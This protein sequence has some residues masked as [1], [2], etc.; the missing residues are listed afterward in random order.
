M[1]ASISVQMPPEMGQ[2]S[3]VALF[4]RPFMVRLGN[5]VVAL[6]RLRTGRGMGADGQPFKGYSTTPIYIVK[7]GPTGQRLSPKGGRLSR[8][9][10]SVYYEGGYR[11]FKEQSRRGVG[12]A[13]VDLTLS[14]E[15]L[16]SVAVRSASDTSVTVGT[17]DRVLHAAKVDAA[18]PFVGIA[19]DEVSVLEGIVGEQVE[20]RLRALFGG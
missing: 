19:P 20:S 7:N 1:R 5:D 16:R 15:M 9:G 4:G 13:E 11:Q 8:T 2:P 12:G 6:I 3:A 18:R 17:G 14:G 10:R